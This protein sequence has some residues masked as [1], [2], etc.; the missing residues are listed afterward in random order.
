MVS[1]WLGVMVEASVAFGEGEVGGSWKI[2][3]AVV[4]PKDWSWG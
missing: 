4:S 3:A 1:G 2:S